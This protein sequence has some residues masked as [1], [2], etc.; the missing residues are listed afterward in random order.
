MLGKQATVLKCQDQHNT[1]AI[2]KR[3][4]RCATKITVES[5]FAAAWHTQQ[6]VQV[7]EAWVPCQGIVQ[8]HDD[9]TNVIASVCRKL[10]KPYLEVALG[11]SLDCRLFC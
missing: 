6:R 5:A 3:C 2:H 11:E 8:V 7:E 10:A 1:R 4:A 9:L